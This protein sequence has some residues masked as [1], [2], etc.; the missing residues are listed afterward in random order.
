MTTVIKVLGEGVSLVAT[1]GTNLVKPVVTKP[2]V[3]VYSA[4]QIVVKAGTVISVVI[5]RLP[6]KKT[7]KVSIKIG[8]KPVSIASLKTE[9]SGTA[10][11]PPTKIAKPGKYLIQ[12]STAN[13]S[14]YF[15]N[16]VVRK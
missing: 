8:G 4:P 3:S 12:L 13:G 6:I 1:K 2:G 9:S 10:T 11:L 15:V 16:V 7:L 14:K 5:N